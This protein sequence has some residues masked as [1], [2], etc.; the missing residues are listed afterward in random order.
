MFEPSRV[1]THRPV[2]KMLGKHRI[3]PVLATVLMLVAVIAASLAF[4]TKSTRASVRLDVPSTTTVNLTPSVLIVQNTND[5][6]PG[7]LRDAMLTA[8]A[9]IGP[10]TITFAIDGS[11]PHVITPASPLPDIVDP[12]T[13]DGSTQPAGSVEV[14][15]SLAGS[16]VDGFL[17]FSDGTTLRGLTIK[18]FSGA[19]VLLDYGERSGGSG[20]NV[21]EN[22]TIT[23]NG[24]EGVMVS[25]SQQA[26]IRRNSIYN[27]GLL[28]IDLGGDGVTPNDVGDPD[29]GPNLYQNYPVLLRAARDQ[30]LAVDGRLNSLSNLDFTLD[31]FASTTCDPTGFG[32]GQRYL[33]SKRVATDAAGNARFAFRLPPPPPVGYPFITATATDEN[34]NTSEFSQCIVVGPNNNSWPRAYR[35]N[36]A[37]GDN[38]TVT[39]SQYVDK[40]GQSRWYKFQV[41]PDSKVTVELSNLPVNYDI[42][43]YKDIAAVY[44]A[45]TTPQSQTDLQKLNAE[46][47]PDMFS[48][49]MF[50]PDMFSP[51]MFS[52]DMFSPDMFSPDMFSP[53]MFSP[54]M[55]S[56]DMFSPDM[57]SP[58]MFSPDMFSPDEHSPEC[59]RPERTLIPTP[60]SLIRRRMPAPR[61]EASSPFHLAPAPRTS[62]PSSTRGPAQ[63]T[64]TC[65]CAAA[66]ASIAW[67]LRSL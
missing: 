38:Q 5:S 7:S 65:A 55:F 41:E 23:G 25:S 66:T 13:I 24:K 12:V 15:G 19:G 17:I 30:D 18:N 26:T 54:D 37:M 31:F 67:R 28:G 61:T 56:P 63:V 34:G 2:Q 59:L 3:R 32:E 52:P 10:D 45:L 35:L 11:G 48:P 14:D 40:L 53:D 27:N 47:A 44:Q 50:S 33:S 20:P 51:D 6:G 43:I 42:V 29:A 58:D 39:F 21:I 49:D 22:N 62:G 46:F 36:P 16:N 64:S 57:F 60:R 8:N 1:I 9:Q 4:A